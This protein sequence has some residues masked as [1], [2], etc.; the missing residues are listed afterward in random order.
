MKTY[1]L[2]PNSFNGG[3][4]R[5]ISVKEA[6]LIMG[7]GK[8]FKFPSGGNSLSL[9]YQMISDSVSPIFSYAAAKATRIELS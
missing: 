9:K 4:T 7:F 8:D 5:A 3:D 1:I 2:H 6:S